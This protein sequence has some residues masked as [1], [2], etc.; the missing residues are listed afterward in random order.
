MKP[1]LIIDKY[2]L[3]HICETYEKNIF[4]VESFSTSRDIYIKKGK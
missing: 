1:Y 2:I 4:Y 3:I